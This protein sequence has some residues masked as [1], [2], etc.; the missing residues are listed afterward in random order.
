MAQILNDTM[1]VRHLVYWDLNSDEAG[2]MRGNHYHRLKTEQ[3]YILKGKL[4]LLLL[5]PETGERAVRPVN[6]GDRI[7]VA[8]GVA[9][10]FRSRGYA[11]VL[12]FSPDPYDASDTVPCPAE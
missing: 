8:P 11:Q 7:T 3:Y 12:E 4:D 6:A 1:S 2:A 9:H 10:A 5:D